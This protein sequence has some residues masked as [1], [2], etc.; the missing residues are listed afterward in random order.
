MLALVVFSGCGPADSGSAELL[1]VDLVLRGGTIVDGTGAPPRPADVAVK[2]GRIHT[3]GDVGALRAAREID[4]TGLV[5]APG[6]I[7]MHSHAD[8]ILLGDGDT[9]QRLLAAKILQGVTSVIV[10]NCGLGAAPATPDAEPLLSGINAWMTPA[11]ASAGALSVGEYLDRLES[12]GLVLNAGTLVPHGPVR[13]SSMGLGAGAPSKAQIE[14]MRRDLEAG[15]DSGAFGLSVGLIYP[16]G[17]Y[18]ATDELVEL[19]RAVASRNRLFTCHV[20]GSSETLVRA[21]EELIR[22]GRQSGARVHHS[23]LEAVGERFW[24][25]V[26]RVLALEDHARS[27]G[28]RISHDVFLYT[29]AATMMSAIFPPWALEG[30]WTPCSSG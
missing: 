9:Q 13:I 2:D 8:L 28:V 3:V 14:T 6:F 10:G 5:V 17:M 30:A 22:I 7:D 23:H 19:A 18:S 4:A 15:L 24:P 27:R 21:T 12:T 16:P 25:E 1:D 11:G 20:R 26:A 29:R